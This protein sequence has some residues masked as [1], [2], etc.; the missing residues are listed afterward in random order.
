MVALTPLDSQL[1][2]DNEMWLLN[3]LKKYI[4]CERN[5]VATNTKHHGL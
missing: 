2:L 5:I 3:I 1:I 4:G